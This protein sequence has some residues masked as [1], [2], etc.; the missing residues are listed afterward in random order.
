VRAIVVWLCVAT[1]IAFA[2]PAELAIDAFLEQRVPEELAAEGTLLSRLGV[3]LDVEIVGDKAILSLVDL[4]TKRAV[5]STKLDAL[6]ADR[7]AAVAQVTQIVSALA[8]QVGQRATVP[9]KPAVLQPPAQDTR[10]AGEYEYRQ[11][12]VYF[13]DTFSFYS[14]G[15][16]IAGGSVRHIYQGEVKRELDPHEFFELVGRPDLVSAMNRRRIWGGVLT[17][18]GFVGMIAGYKVGSLG[19]SRAEESGPDFDPR[20]YYAGGLAIITGGLVAAT[21]GIIWIT[22]PNPLSNEEMA[23][24]ATQYNRKLRQKYELPL[25]ELVPYA[26]DHGAGMLVSGRF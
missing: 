4:A 11:Q 23:T 19:D 3:S 25:V 12:A 6:P 13:G 24:L 18:V 17:G 2:Q 20:P 8:A 15:K 9:P 10:A 14:D 21:W 7:E 26:D 1:S 5:A 22:R 16:V